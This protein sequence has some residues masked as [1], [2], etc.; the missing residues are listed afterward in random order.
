VEPHLER[1]RF[2]GWRV[3][4]L[5]AAEGELR[6]NVVKPGDTLLR[7]NGQSIDRPEQFKNVWD[8]MATSSELVLLVRRGGKD[9]TVRY[10]IV[11]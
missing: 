4:R 5:T 11:E 1:G 6:S 7:V 8:S 3:M 2:V 9:S 10:R